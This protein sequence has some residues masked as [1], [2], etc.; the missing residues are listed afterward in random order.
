MNKNYLNNYSTPLVR[1]N[2]SYHG[3]SMIDKRLFLC[4]HYFRY[5]TI[6]KQKQNK[7]SK[8]ILGAYMTF[9]AVSKK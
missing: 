5:S 2:V 3:T 6:V 1:P 8:N 9:G 7:A 4:Y